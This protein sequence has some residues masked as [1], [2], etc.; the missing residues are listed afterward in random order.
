MS[1]WGKKCSSNKDPK[2]SLTDWIW[3]SIWG[4]LE[5]SVP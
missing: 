5:I 1:R 3:E 4:L 2:I